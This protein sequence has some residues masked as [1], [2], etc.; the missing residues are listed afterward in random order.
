LS[1]A[2]GG[3]FAIGGYAVAILGL[4]TDLDGSLLLVA[5]MALAVALALIVAPPMLKLASHYFALASLAVAQLVLLAAIN[6]E[7]ITG[8]ANGLSG[9]P[10]LHLLGQ[11]IAPSR[12]LTLAIWIAAT[13]CALAFWLPGPLALL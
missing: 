1:L 2:Q 12:P 4:R 7:T 11:Q 3:F 5:A 6:L 13:V 9:L 10:P 8:G